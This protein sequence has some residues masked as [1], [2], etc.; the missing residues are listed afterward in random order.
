VTPSED[1]DRYRIHIGGNAAGP[2]VAGDNNHIEAAPPPADDDARAAS[3]QTNT[4][5]DRGTV[6]AVQYGDLHV[7]QHPAPSRPPSTDG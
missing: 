1:G 2:V 5:H 4:A 7:H 3:S 6:Y